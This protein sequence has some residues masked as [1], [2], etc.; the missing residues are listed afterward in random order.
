MD[1]LRSALII[2][3]ALVLCAL[4]KG[5]VQP[6]VNPCLQDEFKGL[7]FCNVS[8]GLDERAADAVQRLTQAEKIDALG[9]ATGELK[10]IGLNAYNWWSEATHGISHV[11][12]GGDTPYASNVALPI[13]TACS[14]NRT[15]WRATGAQIGLEARAFMNAGSFSHS[16]CSAH[17]SV[18]FHWVS[19][20]LYC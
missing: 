3:G 13:T 7:P 8:L 14:F 6:L 19:L 17:E 4:G 20:M 18:F 1:A 9:T 10:S 12:F 5:G 2:L 15:L 11:N 16:K